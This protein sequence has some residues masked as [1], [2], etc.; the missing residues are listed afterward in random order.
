MDLFSTIVDGMSS[1]VLGA[2]IGA[3]FGAS[4]LLFFPLKRY[5]EQKLKKAEQDATDR[6]NFQKQMFAFASEEQS[7]ISKYLFWRTE[8][9]IYVLDNRPCPDGQTEYWKKHLQD[10][11]EDLKIIQAKR[12]DAEREQIA[13]FQVDGKK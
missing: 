5:M 2:I 4:G 6:V 3:I 7:S 1:G 10:C 11:A 9:M 13:E 8:L 12:K